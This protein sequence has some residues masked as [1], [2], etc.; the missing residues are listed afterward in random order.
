[1]K[2]RKLTTLCSLMFVASS[3]ALALG[4]APTQNV[5]SVEL[6]STKVG[7][8]KGL[9]FDTGSCTDTEAARCGP[10][11]SPCQADFVENAGGIAWNCN[12]SL[13]STACTLSAGAE[14]GYPHACTTDTA[15]NCIRNPN[16]GNRI[17]GN[18]HCT[19]SLGVH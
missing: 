7:A 13:A 9:C 12:D 11:T 4:G 16:R 17:L 1:M 6:A 10:M 3:M 2:F 8:C 19:D 18:T 5:S 15:G 14:C